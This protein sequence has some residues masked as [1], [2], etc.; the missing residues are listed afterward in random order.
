SGAVSRQL[1][2]GE[3]LAARGARLR[4]VSEAEF[5]EI[6]GLDPREA[7]E[8]KAYNAEQIAAMTGVDPLTLR[9]W[10][11]LSLVRSRDGR[12]DFRYIV[13]LRTIADLVSL[14]VRPEVIASSLHALARVLPGTE[15]PLAQLR[16]IAAGSGDLL[17]E[18]GSG[19]IGKDGQ[20]RL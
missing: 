9:R 19:L 11:Q 7:S 10:V 15:R 1:R 18:I 4:I 6:V 2:R 3:E 14:G 17:A 13:S 12:Y 8:G 5:R 20:L 16:L